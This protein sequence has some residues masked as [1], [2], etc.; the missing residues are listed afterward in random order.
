MPVKHGFYYGTIKDDGIPDGEG[1][2][3]MG[4]VPDRE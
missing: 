3:Y 4:W 1:G 2:T